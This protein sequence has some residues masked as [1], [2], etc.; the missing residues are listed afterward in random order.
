MEL[1]NGGVQAAVTLLLRCARRC[2]PPPHAPLPECQRTQMIECPFA[3]LVAIASP[4][5]PASFRVPAPRSVAIALGYDLIIS[6][7]PR[8]V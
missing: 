8:K 5:G 2:T 6:P 3:P 1:M 7:G 4:R